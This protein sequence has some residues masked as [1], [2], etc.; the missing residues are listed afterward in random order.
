MEKVAHPH[1]QI[2]SR[3]L[4]LSNEQLRALSRLRPWISNLCIFL[5]WTIILGTIWF[6]SANFCVWTVLLGNFIIST[7]QHALFI[8]SHEAIHWRL[9]KN[10][11]I[12]DFVS[13]FFC[14]WP[15]F[16][17]TAGGRK[18]HGPHHVHLGGP[19]DA[20]RRLWNTHTPEGKRNPEWKYP[21]PSSK[22]FY[23]FL[24][25]MAGPTGTGWVLGYVE[26][27]TPFFANISV[28]LVIYW[29]SMATLFSIFHLWREFCWFWLL[30]FC[31][32]HIAIMYFRIALEHHGL[33]KPHLVR[34]TVVKNPFWW[35]FFMPYH[36][37][38][39][40]EHHTY[41]SIP[42]YNLPAAHE[43]LKTHPDYSSKAY[44]SHGFLQGVSELLR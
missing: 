10:A 40:L 28:N 16:A 18:I 33:P 19:D 8:L 29:A 37:G 31:T 17:S 26:G 41:P 27:M 24:V 39:H 4:F 35:F 25:R 44:V 34:I 23:D 9:H 21:K 22:F 1:D 6:C 5:E 3:F 12:N 2:E 42:F 7:R 43:L 30:P 14:L 36:V 13:D 32:L 15:K 20:N 38:L 11:V